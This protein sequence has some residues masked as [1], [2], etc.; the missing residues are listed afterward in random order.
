MRIII[1]AMGGDKAPYEILLGVRDAICSC[2]A[3]FTLVG[4]SGDIRRI[5]VDTGLDTDRCVIVDTPSV[6]TMDD[7]PITAFKRKRDSS[8]MVGLGLLADGKGDAF[9]S[10]GNTGALFTGATFIVKRAHGVSRAAIGTVLP[11]TEPCLLMDAG[12]NITVSA[13]Y[14]EQFA[15]MGSAYMRK[16][17][18]IQAPTV[19]L[20]NNGTEDGKGTPLQVEANS[21]LKACSA[22]K[23]VGNVE[24]SAALFGACNVL[25]TDGF[26]GNIFLKTVEGTG[27][28]LLRSLKSVYG[29]NIFTRLS[30]LMI[31][32]QLA[33]MKK[34]FDPSEHGGS[35]ILGISKPVIKAHG[36]SDAKAIKNAVLE[37]IRYAQSNVTGDISEAVEDIS[38][39]KLL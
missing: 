11:S 34:S 2:D 18:G 7:D 33:K 4:N 21:R 35:P 19:G 30:A 10:A 16:M 6:I 5:A 23:Y 37:A 39:S 27:K 13:E 15:V 20:L 3:E 31:R 28:R 12:A 9:V 29:K 36:S 14:L 1:D 25:V 32:K 26:T 8:M 17:Y 22:I 24:G 38:V